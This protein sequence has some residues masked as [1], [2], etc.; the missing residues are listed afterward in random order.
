MAWRSR[1]CQ[2]GVKRRGSCCDVILVMTVNRDPAAK[3][4]CRRCCQKIALRKGMALD[5]AVEDAPGGTSTLFP[6]WHSLFFGFAVAQAQNRTR[7][8][9]D[10]RREPALTEKRL[11]TGELA[12][13]RQND[14][15]KTRNPRNTTP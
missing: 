12:E 11:K 6:H 14:P 10:G 15:R 4:F 2:V 5:L 3:P 9:M 7:I 1:H 8:R 13:N